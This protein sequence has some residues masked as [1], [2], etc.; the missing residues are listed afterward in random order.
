MSPQ[1]PPVTG[2]GT[3]APPITWIT[4]EI[5]RGTTITKVLDP[6][7]G[8]P[9]LLSFT[10]PNTTATHAR[11]H[12]IGWKAL[13]LNAGERIEIRLSSAFPGYEEQPQ[14]FK[15][16]P[17]WDYLKQIFKGAYVLESGAYGFELSEQFPQAYTQPAVTSSRFKI[18]KSPTNR[19]LLHYDIV[20]Y[21]SQGMAHEI[22]P[23]VDVE[24]DP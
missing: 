9:A 15:G 3:A 21:D 24:P 20:F 18:Q 4:I 17:W 8:T 23:D 16:K 10:H 11:P 13:N 2:A 5:V 6:P 12:Q 1:T 19:P 7:V 14:P 22:D